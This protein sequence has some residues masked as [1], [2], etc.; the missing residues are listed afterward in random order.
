SWMIT[1]TPSDVIRTSISMR[2]LPA[3]TAASNAANVF[4]GA[5]DESPRWA[6]VRMRPG[7]G[8]RDSGSRSLGLDVAGNVLLVR[9][10]DLRGRRGERGGRVLVLQHDPFDR[11]G[12]VLVARRYE[13]AGP[14]LHA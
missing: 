2:S 13:R 7:S 1:G 8:R 5:D 12:E 3:A 10:L 6:M 11:G 4:S 9:G 14:V